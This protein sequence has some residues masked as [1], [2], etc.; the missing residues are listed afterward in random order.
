MEGTIYL[1]DA[2]GRQEY[3]ELPT[4]SCGQL[5]IPRKGDLIYHNNTQQYKVTS[6]A[7]GF[8]EKITVYVYANVIPG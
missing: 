6:V 7:W 5:I 1:R 4:A 8:G 3:I 2:D